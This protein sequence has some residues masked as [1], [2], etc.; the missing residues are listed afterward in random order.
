MRCADLATDTPN[1]CRRLPTC[2]PAVD[3]GCAKVANGY[4]C[5]SKRVIP[6]LRLGSTRTAVAS[7]TISEQVHAR[8]RLCVSSIVDW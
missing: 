4:A 1:G 8:Q 3:G 7:H 5:D 6:E 2:P